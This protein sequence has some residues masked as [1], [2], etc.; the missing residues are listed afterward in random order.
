MRA[1]LPSAAKQVPAGSPFAPKVGGVPDALAEAP[2]CRSCSAPMAFLFQLP[3][4]PDEAGL[5]G[6]GGASVFRCENPETFCR[7]EVAG[8]GANAAVAGARPMGIR[9]ASATYPEHWLQL[10]PAHE[11]TAGLSIDPNTAKGEQLDRYE[12]A[13]ESAPS[14]K[15]GGVPG[16]L[17][18]PDVPSHC[19]APMTFVA[20]VDAQPWGLHFGDGGRGYLFRCAKGCTQP[21]Q[22]LVQSY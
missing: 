12:Q 22:F 6:L 15:V 21:L 11:D 18:A 13:K 8:S 10:V 17:Q 20:Q 16:W 7:S 1:L 9:T 2:R 4:L 3:E 5:Q 14:S 19:G